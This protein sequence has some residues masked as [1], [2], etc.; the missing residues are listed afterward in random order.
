[1]SSPIILKGGV[2]VKI[3]GMLIVL[4]AAFGLAGCTRAEAEFIAAA[5]QLADADYYEMNSTM[6]MRL[7]YNG[8]DAGVQSEIAFLSDV[9]NVASV[10]M[11]AKIIQEDATDVRSSLKMTINPLQLD[12]EY[13]ADIDLSGNKY[14]IIFKI[15]E[16]LKN[17]GLSPEPTPSNINY[18]YMDYMD[19][20][21]AAAPADPTLEIV[22]S[23]AAFQQSLPALALQSGVADSLSGIATITSSELYGWK[24]LSLSISDAQLKAMIANGYAGLKNSDMFLQALG[25]LILSQVETSLRQEAEAAGLTPL[26][27]GQMMV[28]ELDAAAGLYG[29]IFALIPILGDEG[30]T[31]T[32]TLDD[33]GVIQADRLITD[34]RYELGLLALFDPLVTTDDGAIDVTLTMTNLYSKVNAPGM[35]SLPVLSAENSIDMTQLMNMN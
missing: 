11:N 16:L 10:G 34:F 35:V 8:G 5:A 15:P 6:S 26:M 30:I 33:R 18:L 28:G 19:V 13:W 31:Y 22:K 7:D 2:A 3:A 1:V 4:L 23:M 32:I 21:G 27:L 20:M 17:P 29:E 14:D 25:G 12:M 9:L 24:T